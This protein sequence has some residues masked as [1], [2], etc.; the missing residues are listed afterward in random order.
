[1]EDN[2]VYAAVLA[3][4]MK[5]VAANGLKG[6]LEPATITHAGMTTEEFSRTA[7]DWIVHARHP[8]FDRLYTEV[9][10]QPMLELLVYPR[11]NGFKTFIVSGGG[12]DFMRVWVDRV[13][14]IPPEQVIGSSIVTKF[15]MQ[16]GVPVLMRLPQL[17]F[18][19]DNVGKPV[20]INM[21]IGRR[22][23]AA[24]GN[25]NGDLQMLQFGNLGP[26]AKLLH[27]FDLTVS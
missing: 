17:N 9:V 22:P 15:E 8:K 6:L 27:S 18:M 25:S 23:I 14:G 19:D 3:G 12:I 16:D 26:A 5:A 2:P 20:A 24:F 11:A 21:H 7:E 1:V 13:Y 4:D 10:Y